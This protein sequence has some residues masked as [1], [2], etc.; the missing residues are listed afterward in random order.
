MIV[1]MND[2]VMAMWMLI[3][4]VQIDK[5]VNGES[6]DAVGNGPTHFAQVFGEVVKVITNVCFT[7]FNCCETW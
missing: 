5:V 4:L 7:R 1:L 6:R 3:P 2:K